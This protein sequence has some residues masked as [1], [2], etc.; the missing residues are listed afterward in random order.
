MAVKDSKIVFNNRIKKL[1]K[2]QDYEIQCQEAFAIVAA[3]NVFEFQ[4]Q[5]VRDLFGEET[6]LFLDEYK[7][8]HNL[9]RFYQKKLSKQCVAMAQQEMMICKLQNHITTSMRQRFNETVAENKIKKENPDISHASSLS[10]FNDF[11]GKYNKLYNS[12][13]FNFYSS[14]IRMQ[15][16]ETQRIQKKAEIIKLRQDIEAKNNDIAF[17]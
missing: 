11:T 1:I 2:A 7:N 13:P 8:L 12:E 4:G 17:Y 5:L 14:E 6:K 10:S 9:I 3:Q 15:A 16:H